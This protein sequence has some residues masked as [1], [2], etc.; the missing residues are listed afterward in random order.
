MTN[1]PTLKESLLQEISDVHKAAYGFRPSYV[2][3]EGMAIVDVQ[4]ALADLRDTAEK[5]FNDEAS[6]AAEN[7]KTFEQYIEKLSND[8]C[9]PRADALRWD[10]QSDG[11]MNTED[12]QAVEMF[13]YGKGLSF[14]DVDAYTEE[15][16]A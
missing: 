14:K 6:E 3:Y 13:F 4:A 1:Q 15:V 5:V 12:R 2:F 8:Y 11:I 10:M 7:K 16:M 9:A